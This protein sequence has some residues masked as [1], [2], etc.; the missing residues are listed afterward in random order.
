MC[1]LLLLLGAELEQDRARTARTSDLEPR[2]EL[3]AARLLVE[4]LLVRGREPLAAVLPREADAGEAGVEQHRAAARASRAT[5]GELLL[6]GR[7]RCA[8]AVLS[9]VGAV[10]PRLAADPRAGT[11]AGRSRRLSISSSRRSPSRRL[12]APAASRAADGARRAC[13]SSAR[14]DGDP[15]QEQVEVVLEGHADAAVHLHAVLDAARRRSRRRTPWPR[16]TSSAASGRSA[17]DR[18]PR[19]RR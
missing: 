7:V 19:R 8:A 17:C 9:E 3:V 6:V 2:R 5:V 14:F 15:P 1:S 10:R 4:R 13:R 12:R 18:R 16:S 11:L